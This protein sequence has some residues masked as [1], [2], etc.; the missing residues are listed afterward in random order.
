MNGIAGMPAEE[1]AQVFAETADRKALAEAIIE[2]D[3]WVC[4]ILKQL[5]SIEALS[6]RL[7][8]KGGTS[9]SKIFHAI[10]RF[11]EDIDLAVD[12]VA[13]G[14]TG[15]RDPS[16]ADISKTRRTN[17]LDEMMAECR[18]Y[19]GGEFLAALRARCEEVLGP[20]ES[21]SLG[22]ERAGPERF[23]FNIRRRAR[24]TLITCLLKSCLNW[25]RMRNSSR[26]IASRSALSSPR[27][28]RSWLRMARWRS[29]R[30]SLNGPSGR[31]RQSFTRNTTG[32]PKS[33]SRTDMHA[34]ITMLPCWRKGRS[35]RRPLLTWTFWPRL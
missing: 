21:W 33:L 18:R 10:N 27:N 31:R 7:L 5:F 13:L 1:R 3:F 20:A 22:Y 9:L 28:F 24:R 12:Y 29:L 4:W 16:R 34:T 25:G 2:K 11:S 35:G 6:G 32:H 17:I 19:I 23:I 14:F 15:D 30:F 8:F 26:T